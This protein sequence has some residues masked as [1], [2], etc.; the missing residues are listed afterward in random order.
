MIILL[1]N[2]TVNH[3]IEKSFVLITSLNEL[4]KSRAEDAHELGKV[5]RLYW[6]TTF[7]TVAINKLINHLVSD[8]VE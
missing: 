4:T 7:D 6:K 1:F 3:K 5:I 2:I 8:F